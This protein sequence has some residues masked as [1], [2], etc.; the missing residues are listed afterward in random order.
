MDTV[1]RWSEGALGR[2]EIGFV[3]GLLE[4]LKVRGGGCFHIGARVW[5][6]RMRGLGRLRVCCI[7]T[8]FAFKAFDALGRCLAL[9][10]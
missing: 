10:G 1:E 8:G 9:Q 6:C 7:A 2:R 4:R 5:G 3:V